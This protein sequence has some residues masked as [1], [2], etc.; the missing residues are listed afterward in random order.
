MIFR[1]ILIFCVFSANAEQSRDLFT[2]QD[3]FESNFL[4]EIIEN[5]LIKY[6]N[7]EEHVISITLASCKEKHRQYQEDLLTK[8]FNNSKVRQF[9]NIIF[10]K[11]ANFSLDGWNTLN[12]IF[13]QKCKSLA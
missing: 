4:S 5:Y 2:I 3:N 10:Q 9:T 7:N 13:I 1:F 11:T 12:L 6:F 8:I